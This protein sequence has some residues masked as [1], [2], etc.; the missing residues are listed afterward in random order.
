LASRDLT[1][2][3]KNAA[4][5]LKHEGPPWFQLNGGAVHALRCRSLTAR[6]RRGSPN[7]ATPRLRP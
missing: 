3:G 2:F 1:V 5:N 7:S 4:H 6:W